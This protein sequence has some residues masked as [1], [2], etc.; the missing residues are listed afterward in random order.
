MYALTYVGRSARGGVTAKLMSKSHGRAYIN[1][2]MKGTVPVP[3]P[4]TV[5][6]CIYFTFTR[7]FKVAISFFI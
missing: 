2:N 3:S 7:D 4:R 6:H 1:Y 5:C